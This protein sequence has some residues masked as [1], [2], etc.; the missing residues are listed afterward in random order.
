MS[1]LVP[2]LEFNQ[3]WIFRVGSVEGCEN[4]EREEDVQAKVEA[5]EL[6]RSEFPEFDH[7]LVELTAPVST[8]S[9]AKHTAIR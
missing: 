4:G 9:L 2:L 8:E 5:G 6:E 1:H 7:L 3:R